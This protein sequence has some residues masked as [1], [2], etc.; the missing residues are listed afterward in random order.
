MEADGLDV[1]SLA[2]YPDVV[3]QIRVGNMLAEHRGVR[4][5]VG[6]LVVGHVIDVDAVTQHINVG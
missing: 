3:G 1:A 2:D 6:Q 4:P 5:Q